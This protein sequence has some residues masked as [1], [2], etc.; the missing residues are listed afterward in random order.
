MSSNYNIQLCKI[1]YLSPYSAYLSPYS[2][3]LNVDFRTTKKPY[4]KTQKG[5][6][7]SSTNSLLRLLDEF[8]TLNWM[9]ISQELE[10]SKV[11]QF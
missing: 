2:V 6:T 4:V 10:Y 3:F 1:T 9:K 11:L 7:V 8:R 5:Q